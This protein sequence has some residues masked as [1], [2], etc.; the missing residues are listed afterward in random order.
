MKRF[1]SVLAFGDSHVAG[2]EILG[3][4][5]VKEYLTGNTPLEEM[6]SQTKPFSFPN[7]L[8]DMLEIPCYNY[9]LSGGS[10][11]RSLRLLPQALLDHPDSL[12]LFCYTEPHRKELYYPDT[13]NFYA[14]DA[15]NY[16]QLGIQWSGLQFQYNRKT[17]P[18]NKYFV[19]H[20]LRINDSGVG[21]IMFYVDQAC[22]QLASEY[23][24]IFEFNDIYY[25][26]I[27]VNTAKILNLES[28]ANSGFGDFNSWCLTQGFKQMPLNHY[29]TYAHTKFAELILF[30]LGQQ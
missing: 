29:N 8:A 26:N 13:G 1:K 18:I 30:K 12:V 28:S 10:N 16:I 7:Q 3:S 6:D 5:L 9:A 24:H 23:F 2:C 21:T 27:A 20:M 4:Q 15:D 17:H 22:Q 25:P 14:R 11:E 19:E